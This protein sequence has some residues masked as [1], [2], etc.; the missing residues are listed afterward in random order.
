[1]QR[2]NG[3]SPVSYVHVHVC[4]TFTQFVLYV[5]VH[6]C[7]SLKCNFYAS[8]VLRT[9]T[10]IYIPQYLL[11]SF[12]YH[13]LPPPPPL[14]LIQ[15]VVGGLVEQDVGLS[16]LHDML[17]RV[18]RADDQT[19]GRPYL[20]VVLSFARHHAEDIAGMLPRKQQ[21]LLSKYSIEL[22]NPEVHVYTHTH[23]LS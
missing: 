6:S 19:P 11:P 3:I 9:C 15:L 13:P 17:S 5:H 14:S 10:C 16:L 21:L 12:S 23:T 18:V 22:P 4:S 8:S 20:T 1:M 2:H 7:G